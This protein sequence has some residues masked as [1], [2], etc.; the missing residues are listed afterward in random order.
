MN[1]YARNATMFFLFYK[2]L[3]LQKKIYPVINVD[4]KT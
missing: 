3:V 2:N 4:Q 1:I